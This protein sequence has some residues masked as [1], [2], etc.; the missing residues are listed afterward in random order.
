MWTG[1]RAAIGVV[2]ECVDVNAAFGVGIIVTS[3]IP[4]D[5][6]LGV[7]GVLFEVDGALHLGVS[8]EDSD[9]YTC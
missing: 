3:D 8:A 1:A 6:G 2:T 9:W 4:R 5:L 7:F